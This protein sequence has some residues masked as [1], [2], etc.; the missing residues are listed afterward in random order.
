MP[1]WERE[2]AGLLNLKMKMKMKIEAL[3]KVY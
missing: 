3:L 2:V 1:V